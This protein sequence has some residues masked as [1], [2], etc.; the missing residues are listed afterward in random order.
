MKF[1]ASIPMYQQIAA[2][3]RCDIVSQQIASGS[4]IGTQSELAKRF[5]VSLIT[6]KKA[7]RIL[8]DERLVV[9]RQGKGTFV[10]EALLQEGGGTFTCLSSAFKKQNLNPTVIIRKMKEISTPV[11][12]P[13]NILDILGPKCIYVE[14][15][16]NLDQTVVGFTKIYIPVEIGC[17]ITSEELSNHSL[18]HLCQ[19]KLGFR[20][21]RATQTIRAEKANESI[22]EVLRVPNNTPLLYF[23]RESYSEDGQLLEYAERFFEYTQCSF[24]VELDISD[25]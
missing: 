5:G 18:Y 8:E 25:D 3:L 14:R 10:Q 9:S 6:I 16:H 7:I 24:R 1:S 12:L 21:G 23:S 22:A 15:T 13:E 19:A 17:Q 2:A 20:L 11:T 4:S